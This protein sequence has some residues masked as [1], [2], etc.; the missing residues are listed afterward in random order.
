M[1]EEEEGVGEKG[2]E[3]RPNDKI[4]YTVSMSKPQ[5]H[6]F[7][8]EIFVPSSKTIANDFLRFIMPVWTPG[9]YV[10]REFSKNVLDF[11]AKESNDKI[12]K[13]EKESKNIWRVHLERRGVDVFTRYKVY[14]HEFTVDTSFLDTEHGVINGASVFMYVDGHQN[15]ELTLSVVPYPEWKVI[16]SG[17][18]RPQQTNGESGGRIDFFVPN[19][20]I[21]VD[22]PIEIG[23]Q[24]V[25]Y[26]EVNGVKH[27]VSIFGIGPMETETFLSDLKKIVENTWPICGEIPY[28]RYVFIVDFAGG[29]TGGGLEHLNSTHCIA[30]RLRMRP[31]EEYR[32]LLGLFSHEFFHAWNVKRM[33]PNGLGPFNYIQETFTKSLWIA[34]GVTSYYDDLILRRAGIVSVGE[35]FDLFSTNANLMLSLPGWKWESAEEA[36]FDTWIKFYRPDE[37]TPNVSSSYYVQGAVIGWMIDMEIRRNSNGQRTFDDV[38]KKVYRD[39]YKRENRGYTDEEFERVCNE[40]A[41]TNLSEEI[42]ERRVRGRERVDFDKYLSYAGLKLGPKNKQESK[43][44]DERQ[45]GFLGVKLKTDFGKTLISSRLFDTPAEASGLEVGDEIIGVDGL[46]LDQQGLSFYIA[47]RNP[48]SKARITV[49]RN[50]LLEDVEVTIGKKPDFEYRVYKLDK[51]SE[52]QKNLFSNW[53]LAKWEEEIKYPEYT[54]FPYRRQY[55][56]YI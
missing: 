26:F 16:S 17:L 13:T 45:P 18:D 33:R 30:P 29:A 39:T 49:A 50:G 22:S 43:K 36:S 28:S 34:E 14:A 52:D 8:V 1:Q 19:F 31:I 6:Y 41:G 7:E 40:V 21:L 47:N 2:R 15:E 53:M 56:D 25:H 4:H 9:S 10:V 20:D 3:K 24:M 23:N 32:Q 48:D 44:E 46:R 42:F 55:F 38:M 12:L 5:T 54:P 35:Y 11:S 37:N 27:E 51:A